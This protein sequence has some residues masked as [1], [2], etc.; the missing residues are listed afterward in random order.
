M[1]SCLPHELLNTQNKALTIY[2]EET[3][4]SWHWLRSYSLN[5]PHS[6][7]TRKAS[8]AFSIICTKRVVISVVNNFVSI[9]CLNISV[10]IIF[11]HP[12]I[13][14]ER[15]VKVEREHCCY[16]STNKDP[17]IHSFITDLKW[18][19]LRQFHRQRQQIIVFP[20]PKDDWNCTRQYRI[21]AIEHSRMNE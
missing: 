4:A 1:N 18:I 10:R 19:D 13:L 11:V 17:L 21:K 16:T 12:N 8:I 9:V 5:K 15:L 2:I 20:N 14:E 3:S 6:R 7:L